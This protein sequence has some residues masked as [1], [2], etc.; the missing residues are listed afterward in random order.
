LPARGLPRAHVALAWRL[1]K[2]GITA[3]IIGA[4]KPEH[5]ADAVA[6]LEVTLTAE[7][8]ALE[9]PYAPHEVVGL[10]GMTAFRGRVSPPAGEKD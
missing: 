5:L 7:E 10:A 9:T 1:G 4:T 8:A 3:P 2:P 6:A